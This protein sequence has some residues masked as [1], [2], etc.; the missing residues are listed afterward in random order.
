MLKEEGDVRKGCK[1]LME[2]LFIGS[3][4]EKYSS[5]QYDN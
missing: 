4:D 5:P 1:I 3:H 2:N